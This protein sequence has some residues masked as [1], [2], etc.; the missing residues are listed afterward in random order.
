M[1]SYPFTSYDQYRQR[2]DIIGFMSEALHENCY[3]ICATKAPELPFLSVQEG[4]CMRNCVTKFSVFYPT[5]RNNLENADYRHYEKQLLT[6]V[7]KKN[8]Q[9]SSAMSDPWEKEKAALLSKL[10][11]RHNAH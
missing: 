3:D 6:E 7:A 4:T 1:D 11:E 9:L 2:S 5:L 10:T 8:P